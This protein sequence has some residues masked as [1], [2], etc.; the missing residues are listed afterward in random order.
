M[1]F[2]NGIRSV[3]PCPLKER[4]DMSSMDRCYWSAC[5]TGLTP[6]QLVDMVHAHRSEEHDQRGIVTVRPKGGS[7]GAAGAGPGTSAIEHLL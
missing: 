3:L 4:G 7:L 5:P 6:L 2:A 1:Q